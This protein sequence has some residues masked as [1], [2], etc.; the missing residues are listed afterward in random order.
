MNCSNDNCVLKLRYDPS[1]VMPRY[2]T[3]DPSRIFGVSQGLTDWVGPSSASN[4][5]ATASASLSA[6]APGLIVGCN[7][8][9]CLRNW[10][11]YCLQWRS[12][13]RERCNVR[14]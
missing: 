4:S 7:T 3:I 11:I 10:L 13:N 5:L 14:H 6:K 9:G 8:L 2:S 1:G 12:Y